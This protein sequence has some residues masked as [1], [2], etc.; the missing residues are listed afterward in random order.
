MHQAASF[1][2][3][4]FVGAMAWGLAG[5]SA[6]L[7]QPVGAAHDLLRM[8]T[9]DVPGAL[10]VARATQWGTAR[11]RL[12]VAVRAPTSGQV[13]VDAD[14]IFEI[15][16]ISKV[17][18][19]LLVAMAV[20]EGRLASI[21]ATLGR[22]L[23][24]AIGKAS[25]AVKAITMAQLLT[26]QSCL[27]RVALG[28][29]A[30]N[31]RDPYEGFT[32]EMMWFV[33]AH[34]IKLSKPSP[35]AYA[36]S[37]FGAAVAGEALAT[38]Y[39]KPWEALVRE[40]IT[41]PLGMRD[42][43]V[44]AVDARRLAP[45]FDGERRGQGWT[46]D[47]YNAAGALR[48]TANDLLKFSAAWIDPPPGLLGRAIR[49]ASKPLPPSLTIGYGVVVDGRDAP[50][51]I[52]VSHGG[53]TGAYRAHWSVQ[54]STGES[55]IALSANSQLGVDAI[56]GHAMRERYPVAEA[57]GPVDAPSITTL[58]RHEGRFE[59]PGQALETF[60]VVHQGQLWARWTGRGYFP[61]SATGPGRFASR[62]M[63]VGYAFSADGQTLHMARHGND[64]TATRTT[65]AMPAHSL[66]TDAETGAFVGDYVAG[67]RSFRV[68]ARQGQLTV[69]LDAQPAFPVFAMALADRFRYEAVTAEILFT[70]D[71][72]RRVNGLTL[73]QNGA[74]VLAIKAR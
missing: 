1:G 38:L 56:A 53:A 23:G 10:L 41:G 33:L 57:Q 18:N 14:T 9:Q 29:K 70:R 34:D 68:R 59:L 74:E 11:A 69:Q 73:F 5:T 42:T 39:G 24:D 7:A 36:Y 21:D 50:S 30:V 62:A 17:F 16:S 52:T 48:S 3:R 45:A 6:S 44:V 65:S 8:Q 46:L 66:M 55:L 47:A 67:G 35:C 72:E 32:R 15:G 28:A 27:P 71:I 63:G 40:R 22:L 26:H 51:G 25:D 4:F 60:F 19:G 31:P 43:D 20:E 2:R 49:R 64:A 12:E 61:L 13:R 37:N 54:P 58:R